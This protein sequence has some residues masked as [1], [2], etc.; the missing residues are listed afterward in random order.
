MVTD[1][2]EEPKTVADPKMPTTLVSAV[3][4]TP[5]PVGLGLS[6]AEVALTSQFEVGSSSATILDPP[7]AINGIQ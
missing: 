2:P 3:P 4:T 5:T 6:L 7:F 1:I